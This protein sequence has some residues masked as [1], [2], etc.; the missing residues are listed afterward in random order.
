MHAAI[1][2]GHGS[3][4]AIEAERAFKELG[5]DSRSAVDL[6]NRLAAATA[7]RLPASLLFDNPTPAALAEYLLRELT[8]GETDLK[9]SAPAPAA[10]EPL[11][12]V[13]MACRYPGGV[14]SPEQLWELVVAGGDA[15]SGF[16]LDRGWDLEALYDPD[17][18]SVGTTY[19]R[20]GGFLDDAA[21][22][23]AAFFGISPR[24]A[25]S[26]DPQQRLL[27]ETCWEAIEQ[28]G[29]DPRSLKG[30]QTGVFAGAGA[31][32]CGAA[33]A[34]DPAESGGAEGYRL[35]GGAA[36]VI[37]G[38]VA[39]AL[40]LQG[41]AI[42]VDTACSSSLVALHLASQALREGDCSLAL[43][44]GVTVM[45]T[46]DIFVEFARQRGLAPDGRCKSFADAADGTAW[47]EGVGVLLLERLSEA[48]R[49]GHRVLAVVRGSAVNQD[50]ASNGLTAPNGPSQQQVILR[51]LANA[52]VSAEEVEAVEAHGTGTRLGDPIEA[53]ALL[54][55]YGAGR[56]PERPLWLGSVKSNIGHTQAAAGVAGVIKTAMAMRHDVLPGTLHVDEPSRQVDWTGGVSLLSE[57]RTWAPGLEPRR[58][59]VSS[60]GISG[61]NAHVIIEEAPLVAP[62]PSS[63]AEERVG[64]LRAIPWLVSARSPEA[65]RAQAERM[66]VAVEAEPGF[67]AAE[68]GLSLAARA[69]FERRAVVLGE[70]REELLGGLAALASGDSASGAIEGAVGEAGDGL[71]FLFTGQ[72]AQRVGMGRR[73]YADFPVFREAF[74]E[75]CERLDVLLGRS[76]R[77][78]VFGGEEGEATGQ[79]VDDHSPADGSSQ[80]LTP[81]L[82]DQTLFT[83]TGL[84]AVEVALLRLVESLGVR[85]DYLIGHS[86]GELTAAY[87]AGVFSLDDAC[88][89]VAARGRLMGELPGGGAMVAAQIAEAEALDA[90]EG[91]E[92][93][94]SLAAV[95]GPRSIVVSGEEDAVLELAAT[96][97]GQGSKV[98]RLQ[99]SHAFHSPRMDAMLDEFAAVAAGLSFSEPA[100]PLVSNLTGSPISAQ[101]ICSADYWTRHVRETVRFADGVR[102]LRSQGVTSFLELGPDG[103]LSGM[104]S[105]C[106]EDWAP[107][108]G[109]GPGSA[110][111]GSADPG[112]A[113]GSV[114]APR[115]IVAAPVLRAGREEPRSLLSALAHMWVRGNDIDW[116]SLF[117]G[118]DADGVSLPTYAFQ[119]ERYWSSVARAS[120]G[121]AVSIGQVC[122]GHPLLG[123]AEGLADGRGWLLTGRLSLRSHPW[124][125]DHVVGGFALLPGTAFLELA[126]RAGSEVEC[127][128]VQELVQEAPLVLPAQG[129]M[130]LQ[131]WVGESESEGRRSFEIHSCPES[132]SGAGESGETW[133]RHATGMLAPGAHTSQETLSEWP[134]AGATPLQLEDLYEALAGIGLDYGPA[135]Q[136]LDGAWRCGD[137]VFA[138]VSLPAE[139]ASATH[140]FLV[141]PVLLDASLHALGADAIDDGDGSPRVPFSWNGVN[142]HAAG[143]GTLRV[144]ISRTGE[145]A[146]SILAADQNGLPVASVE[147]LVL[148]A[149]SA[150][151]L[152]AASAR[153]VDWLYQTEWVEVGSSAAGPDA[154]S[155]LAGSDAGKRIGEVAVLGARDGGLPMDD[156]GGRV[157]RHFTE[158]QQVVQAGL[159]APELV[160]LE[161]AGGL[162]ET[163]AAVH[164]RVSEV[165]E[166]LQ[167][168]L[169]DERFA[170]S[171]L[172]VV[173]AGAVAVRAGADAP[174]LAG[175]AVW[176]LVSSAQSEYPGR[177]VLLDIDRD[178]SA[179]EALRGALASGEER[180]AVRDGAIWAPRL[181]R[182]GARGSRLSVPAEAAEWCLREGRDGSFDD[183]SLVA[184]SE[185]TR[186]LGPGE[187]RVGVR[188]AGLNFRD[189]LIAL[190]VYPERAAIGGEGAGVVLEVGPAVAGLRPGDRVMGLL[191]GAFGPI[192]VSDHRLLANLPDGWSF[193]DGASVP[194]VFLTAHYALVDLAKVREGE[195]LLVHAGAGGVG[196]AAIQLA[197]HLGA[198]VFATA[199]EGK[200]DALR[201]MGLDDD[202]I[203]SSRDLGFA[204]RFAEAT[205][206]EGMDVVL[207]CLVGDFVDASLGLLRSGGRFIEMGKADVRDPRDV[208]NAASR[209]DLSSV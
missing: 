138:E 106:L 54:A 175:G 58:A 56:S 125:G 63:A 45:S 137:E 191:D 105:E 19:A 10:Q 159:A 41:P 134:P 172:V 94:A 31:F 80:A 179:A 12:I 193:A 144:R 136:A 34:P 184:K 107:E 79:E 154:G 18:D 158:L 29:I 6:R 183:L 181:V 99:V 42:T 147:S 72:G 57:Q 139:Q 110:G 30:S 156:L 161:S 33:P 15:I 128:C 202:H 52:G 115:P 118:V 167:A 25:S 122:A 50:G 205:A 69:A 65:L 114:D 203:A 142:L 24:E 38:R 62:A 73:L 11:A 5:F 59:G 23:D 207:D 121:D 117:A 169:A 178:Q 70:G 190:G 98:K 208:A 131:I 108:E 67:G 13:G 133:T 201:A 126:L 84:F 163:P 47:A 85:P 151:Q 148:R 170:D 43:A 61:T 16:P 78:I 168:W 150:E 111:L 116:C 35:T 93:R 100:I 129:G 180:V 14:L 141:H 119:G 87:A 196:M 77:E 66:R 28:A 177:L 86:V 176:G 189:V 171:R 37:S 96:W 146:V 140:G 182:A 7:L 127:A 1:V 22:F 143:V 48:Q 174:E 194:I 21:R 9:T 3:T 197:T 95:N 36:S 199:G 198:E 51:A 164:R 17:P 160:L 91:Y 185:P 71:A 76:L 68:V 123:A 165:L 20:G 186:D 157:L 204:R 149:I 90:L 153:D 4:A 82:L 92:G 109:D 75:V 74:E 120:E 135:F 97:E 152:G 83:Q 103:V 206:G 44:G 124:L 88:T 162:E 53:Q 209:G 8:A 39:Y 2:L 113:G 130:R 40:G 188:A 32:D 46:P 195:R 49:N 166:L 81:G 55:T 26:M 60:F 187:V 112:S 155:S 145:H 192:A 104:T 101:E 102:W 200:W 132:P 89:L 27:L 64:A 173:T